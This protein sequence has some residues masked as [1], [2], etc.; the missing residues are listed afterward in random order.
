ML[1][2]P[3][4]LWVSNLY[5]IMHVKENA[6]FAKHDVAPLSSTVL[7]ITALDLPERDHA[8]SRADRT[9]KTVLHVS[10]TS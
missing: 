8:P 5:E 2:Y 7:A 9:D 1:D 3:W 10:I 6:C 4:G